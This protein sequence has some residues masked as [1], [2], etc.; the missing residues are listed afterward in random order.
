M[1]QGSYHEERVFI[2][3]LKERKL[4][5]RLLPADITI[6]DF[7]NSP[8][9]RSDNINLIKEL[10][11]EVSVRYRGQIPAEYHTFILNVC[12]G[13]SARALLQCTRAGKDV[14]QNLKN[15]CLQHLELLDVTNQDL[16]G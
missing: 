4:V 9:L 14:L 3:C 5:T 13:S 7:L 10:V 2:S 8:Q 6:E 1:S 11:Q 15:F 16:V 12:K